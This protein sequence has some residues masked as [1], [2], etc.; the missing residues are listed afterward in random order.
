MGMN[1]H[2]NDHTFRQHDEASSCQP[3]SVHQL[4]LYQSILYVEYHIC[5]LELPRDEDGLD[6]ISEK[7]TNK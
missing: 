6:N 5:S 3:W 2:D 7:I 1:L 4:S